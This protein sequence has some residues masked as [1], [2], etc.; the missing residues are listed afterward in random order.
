MR[1]SLRTIDYLGGTEKS[2]VENGVQNLFKL[3]ISR[4]GGMEGYIEYGK[5][6]DGIVVVKIVECVDHDNS[7]HLHVCMVDDGGVTQNVE[8][9]SSGLVQVV[10]GAPNARQGIYAAWIPPKIAVPKSHDETELFIL[11]AREIRGKKSNGMLASPSEL[12]MFENHDGILE[13]TD[14]DTGAV[15]LKPG[16]PLKDLFGL[17]D[18]LFDIENKML[19]HR[20]DGFGQ[21][22]L[23]REFAGIQGIAFRSPEWYTHPITITPTSALSV[24]S[25]NDVLE[26]VPRFMVQ[27]VE[28]VNVGE[29]PLWLKAFLSRVGIKSIN[30]VVDLSNYYMHLTGQPTH[31]FDYDKVKSLSK[32]SVMVYPRMAKKGEKIKLLNGKEIVLTNEDIVIANDSQA[33]ALAGVMGGSETEVDENTKNIV[34]ECATFDMYTVRRATMRHGLF[35]DAATRYTKGQ[36][37]LQNDRVLAKFVS[38]LCDAGAKPGVLYDSGKIPVPYS[39]PIE[40]TADFINERLGSTLTER[41]IMTTLENVEIGVTN[42]DGVLIVTPPFWRTDLELK[43]DIVEEVGRLNGFDTLPLA[44][45]LRTSTP[46][47]HN[48]V[49]EFKKV[50]RRDL[51]ALGAN[52]VLGY[53]FIHGDTLK[54]CGITAPEE[55]C[56]H[57]RNAISPDL[58]YYRPSLMPSLL[59]KVHSNIK[60]DYVRGDD[61][62]FALFEIG[63]AHVKGHEDFDDET[64]DPRE[65]RVKL[66]KEFER[67]SFIFGAEQKT[68][69]RKYDGSAYYMAKMYLDALTDGQATYEP[70]ESNDYPITGPYLCGR[71]AMVYVGGELLGVIGEF[72]QETVQSFKL[73]DYCAGFECDI[74]LLM[75]HLKESEYQPIGAYPKT[76]KDIT[77]SHTGDVSYSRLVN[78]LKEALEEENK[79]H[80]YHYTIMPRDIYKKDETTIH[81]TFRIWLNHPQKTLKTEEAN[82]LIDKIS[83]Y[84]HDETGA[85]RV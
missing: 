35:T 34:I 37:S 12:G 79:I 48:E 61:N 31:A 27:P 85:M 57:I 80:G 1:A 67:V 64:I 2:L 24:E 74:T 60:S 38:D 81:S 16:V 4:L 26:M 6:F 8:R 76:I 40:V 14:A 52:E 15:D 68:A 42:K 75:K 41:I 22:G 13:F 18:I 33:I 59:G 28:G 65:E 47:P 23:G 46:A 29:S 39:D 51:S 19:T 84:L 54:N 5:R 30:S 3:A 82:D 9:D 78:V 77:A 11:E 36:S 69:E 62:E 10:C 25:K 44:L 66:P 55:W 72:R 7:D 50:L 70:L 17:N 32:G 20:P 71:S 58:Q 63:K 43:E 83:R 49:F 53:S 56:Y 45:P 21:I 73:P